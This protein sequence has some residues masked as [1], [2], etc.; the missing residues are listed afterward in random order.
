MNIFF[1]GKPDFIFLEGEA[2]TFSSASPLEIIEEVQR[3][4]E[5]PKLFCIYIDYK[6]ELS[7]HAGIEVLKRLRLHHYHQHCVLFS[8][9]SREE[10]LLKDTRNLILYSQG[11]TYYQLSKSFD[12]KSI[13]FEALS[14]Q[15]V[16]EDLSSF[17]KIEN[18][19]PDNRHIFANWWGVYTLWQLHKVMEGRL[20]NQ[21]DYTLEPTIEEFFKRT[22]KLW[23][24]YNSI[25]GQIAQYL[26]PID[27]DDIIKE[28][29]E[30]QRE[31][32]EEDITNI[33][34]EFKE[35][36]PIIIY[37]DDQAEEGWSDI[38]QKIIYGEKNEYFRTIVPNKNIEGEAFVEEV[39]NK[40]IETRDELFKIIEERKLYGD[41]NIYQTILLI[42]DIRLR[43]E[44]EEIPLD[45]ISG[46]QILKILKEED[47]PCPILVTTASNKWKLYHNIHKFGALAYWQK[48]GL[49]E[50][51]D[52][53][54]LLNNYIVLVRTIYH[55]AIK[56][57][58][59]RF[60]YSKFVPLY[61]VY[62]KHEDVFWWETAFWIREKKPTK[63]PTNN[64]KNCN[65][66]SSLKEILNIDIEGDDIKKEMVKREDI[67]EVI[68]ESIK[69]YL[70]FI[71]MEIVENDYKEDLSKAYNSL[72]VIYLYR[73]FEVIYYTE[74]ESKDADKLKIM[75]PK[76]KYKKT[77]ENK[78]QYSQ[79]IINN[80]N[81]ATHYK[82]IE[83][84][85][86][87]VFISSIFNLLSNRDIDKN[88][89][90]KDEY[91]WNKN[92]IYIG[93]VSEIKENT[94][95]ITT[96]VLKSEFE[97]DKNNEKL[98][99]I[100]DEE[101]KNKK[102]YF[103][104][105]EIECS[106]S[107]NDG[108]KELVA[109]ILA[110]ENKEVDNIIKEEAVVNMNIDIGKEYDDTIEYKGQIKRFDGKR[111]CIILQCSDLDLKRIEKDIGIKIKGENAIRHI[112][113]KNVISNA[114]G[115]NI[116]EYG[117]TFCKTME[118]RKDGTQVTFTICKKQSNSNILEV[119]ID[120][121]YWNDK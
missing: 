88:I 31:N 82:N 48:K 108:G 55:L 2:V 75:S 103:K 49:D 60:V 112:M 83:I 6:P 37:V 8:F 30:Y 95:I 14:Q 20:K 86:L 79:N 100:K 46:I 11:V 22:A 21:A 54:S 70:D 76:E 38:F 36:P 28:L 58:H 50:Q 104:I 52:P 13:D 96:P 7:Q 15:Q 41:K 99:G 34:E 78:S 73:V 107:I 3:L 66:L 33:W 24:Q 56:N 114:D 35:K 89:G 29:E 12:I 120:K 115:V 4:Q 5:P 90:D 84:E 110:V 113:S 17:F 101:L 81:I 27:K 85:I 93:A 10:L 62:K 63:A 19:L 25:E 94:I 118:L 116:Y 40:I 74:K 106:D 1:V 57:K 92:F 80:R 61:K 59:I 65:D 26:N 71:R 9:Y 64:K 42:L 23:K 105:E 45:E 69:L 44:D 68:K 121:K 117:I 32:K 87:Q 119:K 77:D 47:F 53:K 72:I 43:A 109:K 91:E 102:I 39:V 98:K 67:W 16:Y 51:N 111:R 18:Y 97:V